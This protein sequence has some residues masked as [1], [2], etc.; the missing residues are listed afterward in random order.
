MGSFPLGRETEFVPMRQNGF[1]D[2]SK[3]LLPKRGWVGR[4]KHPLGPLCLAMFLKMKD[5]LFSHIGTWNGSFNAWLFE[6]FG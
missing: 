1:L 3:D 5:W 6:V 2:R 4:I